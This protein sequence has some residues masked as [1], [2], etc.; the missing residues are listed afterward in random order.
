MMIQHIAIINFQNE[1]GT[2]EYCL[3]KSLPFMT[4]CALLIGNVCLDDNKLQK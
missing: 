3:D 4:P 1:L 2:N